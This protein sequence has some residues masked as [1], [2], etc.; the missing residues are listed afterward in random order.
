MKENLLL[1]IDY[2]Y[3]V[4]DEILTPSNFNEG[5]L[6]LFSLI[7]LVDI[8]NV[9]IPREGEEGYTNI[10]DI[11]KRQK[12]LHNDEKY[13]LLLPLNINEFLELCAKSKRY[14]N[15]KFHSLFYKVDDKTQSTFL[16]VDL[17]NQISIVIFSGTDDTVVGWLEDFNLLVTQ[18]IECLTNAREYTN[19]NCTSD[20]AYILLGHSKGGLISNYVLL[21]AEP[22]VQDRIII[23]YDLD[24]P[25]FNKEFIKKYK[26]N[27]ELSKLRLICPRKSIVG[28]LFYQFNK[29]TVVA[30]SAKTG[31]TQH[32]PAT[33]YISDDFSFSRCS[34]YSKRSTIN[35]A[36]IKTYLDQL[37]KKDTETLVNSITKIANYGNAKT[38][39]NLVV[40]PIKIIKGFFGLPKSE[41]KQVRTTPFKLIKTYFQVKREGIKEDE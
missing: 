25:G 14:Q 21:T 1:P 22:K 23:A 16:T 3:K 34:N 20:K 2:V 30:S 9:G 6:I 7:T 38:L 37:S 5:D 35:D 33:W 29:A 15:L 39:S 28:R 4:K 40:H 8:A 12:K 11:M 32:N 41:R 24:G 31:L 18:E 17:S 10:K 26:N 19:R 27:P 36:V 13:G